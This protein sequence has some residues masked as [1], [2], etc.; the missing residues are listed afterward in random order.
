MP[1]TLAISG[2]ELDDNEEVKAPRYA[3]VSLLIESETAS[4]IPRNKKSGAN[5]PGSLNPE[6]IAAQ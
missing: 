3:S 5:R 1:I 6:A 2:T 4:L